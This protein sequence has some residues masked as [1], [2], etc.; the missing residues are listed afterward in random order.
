MRRSQLKCLRT[1]PSL[2]A[3]RC[4]LEEATARAVRFGFGCSGDGSFHALLEKYADTAVG[5][6]VSTWGLPSVWS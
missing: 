2:D 5:V 4:E 3:H 1:P 6:A